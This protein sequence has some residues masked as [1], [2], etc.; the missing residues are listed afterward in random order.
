MAILL[1][2]DM[3]LVSE[4]REEKSPGKQTFN[5]YPRPLLSVFVEDDIYTKQ[6]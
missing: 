6:I 3:P 5:S 1:G 2:L 4:V